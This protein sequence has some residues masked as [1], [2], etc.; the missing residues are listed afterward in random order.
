MGWISGACP[1]PHT[2]V[3]ADD[4][5]VNDQHDEYDN[6]DKSEDDE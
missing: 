2:A 1:P 5:P 3:H 6:L 4:E